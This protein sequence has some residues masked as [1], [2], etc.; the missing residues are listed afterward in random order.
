MALEEF[1]KK[2][3]K[4]MMELT[5]TFVLVLTIQLSAATPALAPFAIA[6]ALLSAIYA[7]APISGAHYNPAISLSVFARGKLGLQDLLTYWLFQT[8]GGVLGAL[9][10][11]LIAGSL[12]A[13]AV[14]PG[15]HFVQAFLAELVFTTVLCFVVLATATS[16]RVAGNGYFGAAIAFVVFA[17]A[18]TVG[19]VSGGGFNP[20]VT[21]GLGLVKHFWKLPYMLWCV[22]AQLSGGLLG[23]FLF[24]V[25]DPE[26]FAHF[27]D[28]AH[29]LVDEARALLPSRS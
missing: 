4:A 2:F 17:G 25:V 28:E 26:E 23:A 21:L 5:G 11:G 3:S 27:S 22:L 14:G 20:A 13:L 15:F 12:T 10:G 18:A 7:G 29:G 9:T 16:S 1:R 24:Y 6:L 8:A 19:R